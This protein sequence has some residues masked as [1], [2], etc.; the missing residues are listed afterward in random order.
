LNDRSSLAPTLRSAFVE[1]HH[2]QPL[3]YLQPRRPLLPELVL[4][5]IQP[6]SQFCGGRS[7]ICRRCGS[8][9][10]R[11]SRRPGGPPG[12][13]DGP[14]ALTFALVVV[15][16][17]GVLVAVGSSKCPVLPELSPEC[18]LLD[19]LLDLE[20]GSAGC[21]SAVSRG[22]LGPSSAS[23]LDPRARTLH[24][25]Q[26]IRHLVP[27]TPIRRTDAGQVNSVCSSS[28]EFF[29]LFPVFWSTGQQ[30]EAGHFVKQSQSRSS[31]KPAFH[32]R[33]LLTARLDVAPSL[34]KDGQVH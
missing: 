16:V 14:H 28:L 11:K 32:A 9:L 21:Q 26:V 13:S 15:I 2:S 18:F 19:D 6:A 8:T 23:H 33:P 3:L 17:V 22:K 27:S 29:P 7:C 24:L 12:G 31:G 20:D 25:V 1:F 5:L 4:Q 10:S 34:S 30:R